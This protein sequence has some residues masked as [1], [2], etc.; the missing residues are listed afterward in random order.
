MKLCFAENK[1]EIETKA[2]KEQKIKAAWT[3]E[4]RSPSLQG[5]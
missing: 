2:A 1:Q 3:A 5:S 4:A